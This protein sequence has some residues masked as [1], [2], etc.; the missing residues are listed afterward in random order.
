[1]KRLFTILAIIMAVL[2]TILS[3]LPLSNLAF[4]SAIAAL[5]FAGVAYFLSKKSGDPKKI[6]HFIFL[7][8]IISLVL[9]TYK[10]LFTETKVTN[11]EELQVKEKESKEDASEESEVLD[12]G[13]SSID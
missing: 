3:V 8:C 1:M 13:D 7:L 12:L 10:A 2:A 6:I 11:T 5:I 4:F 9:S